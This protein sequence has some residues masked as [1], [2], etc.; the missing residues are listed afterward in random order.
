M[1]KVHRVEFYIVD[2]NGIYVDGENLIHSIKV[3]LYDGFMLNPEWKT[4]EEFEW[5]DDIDL[6]YSDCSKEDCEKYL[7]T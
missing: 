2:P 5:D 6:N 1:A 7:T 3:R 4:S